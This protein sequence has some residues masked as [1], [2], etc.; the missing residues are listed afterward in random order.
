MKYPS[1]HIVRSL[2]ADSKAVIRFDNTISK[3]FILLKE[4]QIP[5]PALFIGYGEHIITASI[6]DWRVDVMVSG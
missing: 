1:H 5:F 6:S 2:N 4:L 3:L